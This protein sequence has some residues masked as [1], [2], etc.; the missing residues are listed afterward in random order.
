MAE[1]LTTKRLRLRNLEPEDK[2]AIYA[3][4]CDENISRYMNWG[5]ISKDDIVYEINKSRN[6]TF[7]DNGAYY[8]GVAYLK[9]DKL[10]GEIY[11]EK[12]PK[13]FILGYAIKTDRQGHGYAT[14][15]I[16]AVVKKIADDYGDMNI[17]AV[18][19]KRNVPSRKLL[20]KLGFRNNY[21][22][23]EGADFVV[24]SLFGDLV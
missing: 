10:I 9:S 3:L 12:R 17:E 22:Q 15:I 19:D 6:K 1:I 5:A 11:L 8:Y 14:E 2:D 20:K 13:Y 7:V 21:I 18:V 24:Y 16:T 23:V 4:S